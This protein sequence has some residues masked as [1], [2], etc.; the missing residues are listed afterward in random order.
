M[1]VVLL[2]LEKPKVSIQ[3]EWCIELKGQK[4][5]TAVVGT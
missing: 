2:K 1:C 4:A 3:I 5:G